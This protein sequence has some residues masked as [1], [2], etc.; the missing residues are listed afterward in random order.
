MVKAIHPVAGAVAL[1]IIALFWLS[2]LVSELMLGDDMVVLVKTTIPYGFLVLIPA[3]AAAGGTGFRLARGRNGGLVGT[4][5]RRM[6][7]IAGNG[8]LIL[9]PSAFFLAARAE[10]GSFDTAF[11][12][13]QIL[14]LAAGALNITLLALNMRDG[15]KMTAKRRVARMT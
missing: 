12:L 1:A 3:M 4:K 7:L 2:T 9:V 6:K 11:N 5:A 14:E 8:L 10:S 15:L 13:V